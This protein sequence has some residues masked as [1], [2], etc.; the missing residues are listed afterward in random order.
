MRCNPSY[1][2]LGL[3]PIALLSWLAVQLE[4]EGIEADLGRRAQDSLARKGMDWAVPMFAGRDGALTGRANDDMEPGRAVAAMRDTWGVRTIINRSALLE[5]IDRYLWSASWRDGKVVLAG[6]APNEETRGEILDMARARFPRAAVI[7]EMKMA[8]GA[9]DKAPWMNGISFGLQQLAQLRRGTLDMELMDM[10]IAGEAPTSPVYK[11]VR[12][13]LQ[14]MPGGVKLAS[15][16]ITPPIADPFLW[17]AQNTD[18]RLIM[19]GFVPNERLREQLFARAKG[20]FPR[21]A[22]VDRTEVAD[23][24]PDGWARA[25]ETALVQLASLKSGVAEIKARDMNFRGEALDAATA[26]N[27]RKALRLDVPRNFK[28]TEQI[29]Y[30]EP[31]AQKSSNYIMAI[32]ADGTAVEVS[33]YIPNEQ[34][35]AA[36]LD[37]VK[38]RYPGRPVADKMQIMQGAPNGWQECIVVGLNALPRLKAGRALLNDKSLLVSG[39][40]DDYAVAQ[41]VPGD[42]KA[43]AGR[44]C[45]TSTDIKFTGQI[46]TNLSWKA[47]HRRDGTL[48][49]SGDIPDE[50]SRSLLMN[51]A[52]KLFANARI[53]DDMRVVASPMEPWNKVAVRGLEQL[54]R[55]MRGSVSFERTQL[56]LTG[57]TDNQETAQSVRAA[58]G[59][60]LP[61]GFTSNDKIDVV[62]KI[63]IIAEADRCQDL[64]RRTAA[65]GTIN[66]DRAKAELT[67]DSSDTLG[68]LAEV[69]NACPNFRIEIEGHTDSEGTDERNERLSNRRAQAVVDFLVRAGVDRNRLTAVGYGASRPVADNNTAEGRAHNRRIEFTV[70][71]K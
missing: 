2:L 58:L 7:D 5:Q 38:A 36:L 30:P 59:Q 68:A 10:S 26:G 56:S 1:W 25:A 31:Q 37:L 19:G 21:S 16:K 67:D 54:A 61:S 65:G 33:G 32:A 50:A 42:L 13:A 8:R 29:H 57:A 66:F 44:S 6:Y 70:R 52:Q 47:E 46:N 11:S 39:S 43:G 51:S 18:A 12:T 4:H 22:L 40:T 3:I 71:S 53:T 41:G 28:L 24:A 27:V 48:V 35:R 34:A 60:N 69:S 9:P 17:S 62:R 20:L 45:E 49:L 14:K 63:E 55:L 64:L 15:E 23:G